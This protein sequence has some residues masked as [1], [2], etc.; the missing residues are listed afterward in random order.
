MSHAVRSEPRTTCPAA[1]AWLMM[2]LTRSVMISTRSP[3]FLHMICTPSRLHLVS[4]PGRLSADPR[5]FGM[6][7]I[8]ER[9]NLEA[10]G[11]PD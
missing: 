11:F 9:E 1:D 7:S 8:S 3:R 6:A 2:P 4:E 5:E 10:D